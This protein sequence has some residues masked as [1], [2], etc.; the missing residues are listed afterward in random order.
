M[1]PLGQFLG[2]LSSGHTHAAAAGFH[3]S[4]SLDEMFVP[5][6]LVTTSMGTSKNIC[7]GEPAG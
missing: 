4:V 5:L 3:Q 7:Y 6:R 2:L 1:N